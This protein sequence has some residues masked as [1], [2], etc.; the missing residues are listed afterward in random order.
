MM[1]TARPIFAILETPVY[2]YIRLI[3]QGAQLRH[4]NYFVFNPKKA[5]LKNRDLLTGDFNGD[6]LADLL[7][8]PLK[9]LSNNDNWTIYN[10]KRLSKN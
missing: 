6:G 3:R 7:V 10:S 9:A 4:K 2:L 1:V 8:P 5:D